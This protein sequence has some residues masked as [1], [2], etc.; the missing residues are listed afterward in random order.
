MDVRKI[1]ERLKEEL[2]VEAGKRSERRFSAQYEKKQTEILKKVDSVQ[3]LGHDVL[4][5]AKLIDDFNGDRLE[6]LKQSEPK[7]LALNIIKNKLAKNPKIQFA[8]VEEEL[9]KV[10]SEKLSVLSLLLDSVP[11]LK[12]IFG[13]EVALN[14]FAP[15][16]NQILD[17]VKQAYEELNTLGIDKLL[18]GK[19]LDQP[20]PRFSVGD[21][22]RQFFGGQSFASFSVNPSDSSYQANR[23]PSETD[24]KVSDSDLQR[25]A[26]SF[27]R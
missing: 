8:K 7:T 23:N 14:L 6:Y 25:N 5:A 10:Y 9:F 4:Y 15:E 13:R 24:E 22:F 2:Q 16:I 17:E 19:L 21:L 18:D 27:P 26:P 3:Q 11:K 1:S 20:A 12:A